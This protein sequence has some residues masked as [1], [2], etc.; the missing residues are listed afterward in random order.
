MNA[1]TDWIDYVRELAE[2]FPPQN[3][4]SFTVDDLE[5]LLDG[6]FRTEVNRNGINLKLVEPMFD[7]FSNEA[8]GLLADMLTG[9]SVLKFIPKLTSETVYD[10][11]KLAAQAF[12]K[13]LARIIYD[14]RKGKQPLNYSLNQLNTAA[15][16]LDK[17]TFTKE[18]NFYVGYLFTFRVKVT[19]LPNINAEVQ[20]F[21]WLDLP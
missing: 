15:A 18:E 16:K 9:F 10:A 13:I 21:G 1:P 19:Y 8:N 6:R 2:N 14:S 7:N 20:D 3:H 12:G 4:V 5:D 17:V 11:Q